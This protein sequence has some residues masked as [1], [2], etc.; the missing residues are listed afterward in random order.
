[1]GR[2]HLQRRSAT[3]ACQGD[4]A[5]DT[6][7][8]TLRL[9]G[10]SIVRQWSALPN[11]RSSKGSLHVGRILEQG[12]DPHDR[13]DVAFADEVDRAPPAKQPAT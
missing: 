10:R 2:G 1:M 7:P 4:R 3:T 11:L 6:R 9:I 5:V 13:I 12:D 8:V